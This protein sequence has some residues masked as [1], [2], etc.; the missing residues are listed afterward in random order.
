[1]SVLKPKCIF[2]RNTQT[3]LS[4]TTRVVAI[5]INSILF[6]AVRNVIVIIDGEVC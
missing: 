1:M 2:Y 3:K 5:L 4:L 6:I